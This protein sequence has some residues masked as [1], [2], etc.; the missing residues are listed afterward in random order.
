M[1]F[2]IS[3]NLLHYPFIGRKQ[4]LKTLADNWIFYRIFGVYG[5]R[6]VGKSRT[7]KEFLRDLQRQKGSP[8]LKIIDVD[9][10]MIKTVG[11]LKLV[12]LSSCG[13][14]PDDLS[15]DSH[16]DFLGHISTY[17]QNNQS[18]QCILLFDNAEDFVEGN[19]CSVFLS[20]C[21]Y[22]IKSCPNLNIVITSTSQVNF[23]QIR[24][25]YFS[26]EM[27]GMSPED[28]LMLLYR[29]SSTINP[30]GDSVKDSET[31]EHLLKIVELCAGLPLALL[32]VAA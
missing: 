19:F 31:K 27:P 11:Q 24:R 4:F 12:L 2:E 8:N 30:T 20:T 21:E 32:M 10:K 26:I 15:T 28:G 3:S 22:L 25:A 29:I 23:S 18:K 1:M 6:S 17:F 14:F 13:L 7:I 16:G 5:T 9:L